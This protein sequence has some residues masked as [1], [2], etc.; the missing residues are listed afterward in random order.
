M[1]HYPWRLVTFDIDGTL[2]QGH[3]WAPI[4]RAFGS[5]PAYE[6]SN[7]RYYAREIGEDQHLADLLDLATGHTV[8]EVQEIVERTPKLAG[9]AQGVRELHGRG[10]RAALL[11]HN[12]AYV[13]NY[14]RRQY[15][16]DDDEGVNAQTIVDGRIG[17]PT[18]VH[19]DKTG[20]LWALLERCRTDPHEVVHVGDGWADAAVFRLVGGGVALNSR[21]EEVRSAAD[22]VLSTAD[23]RVVVAA[24]AR[25][26]PRAGA[27]GR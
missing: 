19:A 13:T 24:L 27:P 6:R 14:Y 5:L 1:A 11:S 12:P 8:A 25:L 2:T 10:V 21:L 26:T 9:I 20:G 17:A 18:N 16:F 15:G 7:R 3:G 22:L 4:A 23:F